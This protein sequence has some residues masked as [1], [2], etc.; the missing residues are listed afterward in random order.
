MAEQQRITDIETFAEAFRLTIRRDEC[1]DQIILGRRVESQLYFDE[2]QLCLMVLSGPYAQKS[3]W[4]GLGEKVWLGDPY[5]GIQ[6]VKIKNI[7][8]HKYRDAIRMAKCKIR[9][10]P[11]EAQI[12]A[13]RIHGESTRFGDK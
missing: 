10:I 7:P 2:D 12:Q 9:K 5:G 4:E 1:N 6:D 8:P 13:L 3:R 11:T